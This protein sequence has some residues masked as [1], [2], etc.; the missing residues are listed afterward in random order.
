MGKTR[1]S[2]SEDARVE[3]LS[4]CNNRCCVCQTPFV[5]L[6]HIAK[7]TNKDPFSLL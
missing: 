7:A 5:V 3:I 1:N 4:R 2:V 6:H